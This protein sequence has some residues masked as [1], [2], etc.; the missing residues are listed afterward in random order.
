MTLFNN[1]T[2]AG[3]YARILKSYEKTFGHNHRALRSPLR[4]NPV[5]HEDRFED[6]LHPVEY[7]DYS[8][9]DR[10]DIILPPSPASS[11][12]TKV[13]PLHPIPLSQEPFKTKA[14][15]QQ[16]PVTPPKNPRRGMKKSNW[17][18]KF[19]ERIT[20]KLE[21]MADEFKEERSAVKS[22]RREFKSALARR[23]ACEHG[24]IA[25]A[26]IIA[27][28]MACGAVHCSGGCGC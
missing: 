10:V 9:P 17:F 3:K 28:G 4:M 13:E 2:H 25:R 20:Q 11:D 1:Q 16:P 21:S 8:N 26:P 24:D 18:T 7:E 14:D 22:R 5:F 27:S 23:R 12:K 15:Q 19:I 6:L